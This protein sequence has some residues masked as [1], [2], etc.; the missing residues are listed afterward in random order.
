MRF[1]RVRVVFISR[2]SDEDSSAVLLSAITI[3][4]T[5]TARMAKAKRTSSSMK[6][7]RCLVRVDF[8]LFVHVTG[9]WVKTHFVS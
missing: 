3:P 4:V 1:L 5:D 9:D 8:I 6:P 7:F 2:S